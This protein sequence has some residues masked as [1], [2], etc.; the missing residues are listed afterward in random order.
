MQCHRC[1]EIFIGEE[2]HMFCGVCI[3]QI[4][5]SIAEEQGALPSQNQTEGGR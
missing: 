1:D 5:D 4:A 3:K 2:F